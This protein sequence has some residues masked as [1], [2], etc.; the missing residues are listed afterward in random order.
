[1]RMN[2]LTFTIK[3]E[4]DPNCIIYKAQCEQLGSCIMLTNKNAKNV[5]LQMKTY[6]YKIPEEGQEI[7]KEKVIKKVHNALC[8]TG[9]L[10][11][12]NKERIINVE[13]LKGKPER[14]ETSLEWL[15]A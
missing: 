11:N 4:D 3:L 7:I 1:M 15:N 2:N 8:F 10:R 13:L 5:S 14:I 9:L 12:Y 6:L